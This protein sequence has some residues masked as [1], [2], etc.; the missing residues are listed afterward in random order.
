MSMR[1]ACVTA[2]LQRAGAF[3]SGQGR[4]A[5]AF[6]EKCDHVH[7]AVLAGQRERGV[8]VAD[9]VHLYPLRF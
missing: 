7:M 4:I 8:L 9:H 5:F 2:N 1:S 3:V 6:Q